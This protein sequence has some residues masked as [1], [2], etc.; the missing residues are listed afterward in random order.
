[1][2]LYRAVSAA[3]NKPTK[4]LQQSLLL[5]LSVHDAGDGPYKHYAQKQRF[6]APDGLARLLSPHADTRQPTGP[7]PLAAIHYDDAADKYSATPD[8][9]G[10]IAFAPFFQLAGHTSPVVSIC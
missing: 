5:H 1:M 7:C 2:C 3:T 8:V 10:F 4:K 9:V 6:N